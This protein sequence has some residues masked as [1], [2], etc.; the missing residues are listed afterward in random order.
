M[1]ALEYA[2][3]EAGLSLWRRRTA[4]LFAVVAIALALVVLGGL[5]LLTSNV[6]RLLAE[7]SSAAEFSV[8]L[9]EDATS[10]Q[11]GAIEALI[12][13]SG[14]ALGR[15]DVSK[16]QALTRFRRDFAELASLT[17][18]FEGNPFPASVEVR[19]RSDAE[20]DGRAD[21]L[22]A[23]LA[24]AA[25]VA[26]VRYDREWISRIT[27]GL[28][29][30]RGIGLA[31]AIAMAIAAGL[32][33]ASVV[34]LGLHARRDEIEIMQLVGSP[35]AYIRGPFVAEGLMQGGLGAM[36]AL[37]ALWMGFVTAVAWWGGPL[38][39]IVDPRALRFLP[40]QLCMW[41][42]AGGMAVGCVGGYAAARGA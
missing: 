23:N 2:F 18:G 34:R 16:A 10:E 4:T 28:G 11:R 33:V 13:S 36:L 12:D 26:D 20:R 19:V 7:W 22:V 30:A 3:R 8:Y 21:G 32:T 38:A 37:A 25:G 41:L 31:L 39:T 40:L 42:V 15:E 24:A 14:V 35:Y 6:E 27:A 29:A 5:L 9:R 1:R 17:Q